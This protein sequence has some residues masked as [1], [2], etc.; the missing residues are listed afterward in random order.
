[1]NK[2]F[3]L[4]VFL[5]IL[6]PL[7]LD[8]QAKE[9]Y[10]LTIDEHTFELHYELTGEVIAMELDQELTSLLIGIENTKDSTFSISLPD[11]MIASENNEFA[12]L[13]NGLEIDYDLELLENGVALKFFV[14]DGT[15]EIEIIGTHVIPEFPFG[16]ILGFV[17]TISIGIFL[18]KLWKTRF[19]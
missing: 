16:I 17:S 2:T 14:P 7:V 3:I 5:I 18:T 12:V 1:M 15:Q 8:A 11:E 13:V 19:K 9:T 4:F 6:T 10:L